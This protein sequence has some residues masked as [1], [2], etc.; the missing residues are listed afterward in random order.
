MKGEKKVISLEDNKYQV[1]LNHSPEGFEFYAK[2]HATNEIWRNLIGDKLVMAMFQEILHL[3]S[4]L[5]MDTSTDKEQEFHIAYWVT[6]KVISG[7][8]VSAPDLIT[9]I[10]GVCTYKDIRSDRILYAHA[11]SSTYNANMGIGG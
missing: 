9:A 1:V 5:G 2:R 8:T 10:H 3:R 4:Q 7:V 6:D 11:K